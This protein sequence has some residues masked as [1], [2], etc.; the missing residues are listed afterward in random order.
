MTTVPVDDTATAYY[1]VKPP[2]GAS[3]E[4]LAI[5]TARPQPMLTQRCPVCDA[6]ATSAGDCAVLMVHEQHCSLTA[7]S[8][9]AE[10][11]AR[12]RDDA[13][14]AEPQRVNADEPATI[15]TETHTGGTHP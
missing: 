8:M 2:T 1:V 9:L 7:E 13:A 15:P 6:V 14:A 10:L 11:G 12:S 3:P 4:L 5:Y